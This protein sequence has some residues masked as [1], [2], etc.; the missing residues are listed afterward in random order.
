MD[1]AVSCLLL[2]KQKH[3]IDAKAEPMHPPR[4]WIPH[5]KAALS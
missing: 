4:P 2:P 5:F 3:P 1:V